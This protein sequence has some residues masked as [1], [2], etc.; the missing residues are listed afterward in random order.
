MKKN[1]ILNLIV[2]LLIIC[3]GVACKMP[4]GKS[5]AVSTGNLR[6]PNTVCAFLNDMNFGTD[7]YTKYTDDYYACSGT[8]PDQIYY[9]PNG[10]S[11]GVK[12]IVI[13]VLPEAKPEATAK[14][15]EIVVQA[16]GVVWQNIFSK[17]LPDEIKEAILTGKEKYFTKP[18][19][20]TV[21][22]ARTVTITM[23]SEELLKRLKDEQNKSKPTP[24]PT[25]YTVT[26]GIKAP[27]PC[28]YLEQSIGLKPEQY[29]FLSSSNGEQY[30]CDQVK[31]L[32]TS[33]NL[34]YQAYGNATTINKLAL[35]VYIFAQNTEDQ[36]R[37]MKKLI[38]L[39]AIDVAKAASGQKLPEDAIAECFSEIP[40]TSI[41]GES[42]TFTMAPGAD[43]TKPQIKTVTVY[44]IL[45][46]TLT[47][48]ITF[49]FEPI[50]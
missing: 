44:T 20:V 15:A 42:K 26:S 45:S 22:T 21:T 50:Q 33:G 31:K 3:A 12:T 19:A 29:K 16:T 28:G 41:S 34:Q 40:A 5:K 14:N 8:S 25:P 23:P 10:D 4:F 37:E 17:P 38:S 6:D 24:N 43:E 49:N 46:G 2:A 18:V 39:A 13:A 9:N 35:T 11:V 47:K 7:G 1:N 32:S 30:S 48:S 36:K 27:E